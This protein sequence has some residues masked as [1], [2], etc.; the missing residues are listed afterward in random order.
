MGADNGASFNR[1]NRASGSGF[2]A[3]ASMAYKFGA[4]SGGPQNEDHVV[5]VGSGG[6]L[7]GKR[8]SKPTKMKP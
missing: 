4:L 8:H 5:F 1:F 7:F 6:S 2:G 3:F